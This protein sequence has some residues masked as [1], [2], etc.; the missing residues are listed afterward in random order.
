[1]LHKSA[2]KQNVFLIMPELKKDKRIEWICRI[3]ITLQLILVVRGY[4]VWLQTKHQLDSPLIPQSLVNEISYPHV[5]P[6]LI[7]SGL[8][9]A[10]LWLYFLNKR[11]ATIII[12]AISLLLYQL[13]IQLFLQ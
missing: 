10:T 6:G 1:M 2:K 8:M 9:L 3:V 12:G 11:M 7:T 13:W 4:I 5:M